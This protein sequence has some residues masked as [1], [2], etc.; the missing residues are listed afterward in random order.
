MK[1]VRYEFIVKMVTIDRVYDFDAE[2]LAKDAAEN[3][4]Q[5]VRSCGADLGLDDISMLEGKL[6]IDGTERCHVGCGVTIP[7]S[8]DGDSP[9]CKG[10]F[11]GGEPV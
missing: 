8:P 2:F 4:K 5:F 3:M 6:Y 7:Q 9:L 1:E 11:K 10:A